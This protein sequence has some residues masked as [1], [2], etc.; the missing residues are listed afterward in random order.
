MSRFVTFCDITLGPLI[1][2]SEVAEAYGLGISWAMV[3]A[4]YVP[5]F[6]SL[7]RTVS[8]I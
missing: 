8:E 1:S 4:I 5:K 6:S 3:Q 7:S 2:R